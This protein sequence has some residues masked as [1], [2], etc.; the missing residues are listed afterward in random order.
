M[1]EEEEPDPLFPLPFRTVTP[2]SDTRP[3]PGMDAIGWGMLAG[4][5]VILLPLLPFMIIV[6]VI[7]KVT[8]SLSP[9]GS[10]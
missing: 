5:L 2:P 8:E 7:A 4:L 9:G 1:S 3:D 10:R 6:W